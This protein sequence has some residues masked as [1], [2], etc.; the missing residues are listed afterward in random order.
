MTPLELPGPTARGH[1]AGTTNT[2]VAVISGMA[3]T[4]SVYAR[5]LDERR[6][7]PS[8]CNQEVTEPCLGCLYVS[9]DAGMNPEGALIAQ[10]PCPRNLGL[11]GDLG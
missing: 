11:R 3:A 2:D 8:P 4:G 9:A 10:L 7:L 1:R 6:V 5:R